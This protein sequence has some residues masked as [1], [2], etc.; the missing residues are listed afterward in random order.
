METNAIQL[1]KIGTSAAANGGSKNGFNG[2]VVS[3]LGD[4]ISTFT[5]YTPVADGHNLTHRNRYPQSDLLT[6][7]EDT[8]WYKLIKSLG[9]K[10]GI[11]DSWAGSRV[12]NSSSTNTGDQGPDACMASNTR[13]TNLGANGTPDL[14]LFYGG[15]NDCAA[16]VTIG[17]FDS[18][19]NHNTVDLDSTT[20]STFADAYA[21]A[22]M[23]LQHYYPDAKIVV[24]LPTYTATY[25][26]LAS[27]DA[28]NEVIKE[29]CDYF[30]VMVLDLRQSGI[31]FQNKGYTLG[32]GIHPTALG[33]DLIYRYIKEK[34][35]STYSLPSGN[36][37]V[38]MITS[39]LYSVTSTNGWWK[40]VDDGEEYTTVLAPLEDYVME[41][42][43][44]K[45]G[46]VDIT[47][48]V[49]DSTTKTISI[50]SV[51]GDVVITAT[52]RYAESVV[53]KGQKV[54]SNPELFTGNINTGA[55][56]WSY[57]DNPIGVPINTI[58]F[59]TS[60]GITDGVVT[61][62]V[63]ETGSDTYIKS[64]V[65]TYT[66]TGS[67]KEL[68]KIVFPE[69]YTL[70]EGQSLVLFGQESDYFHVH[71]TMSVSDDG[72]FYKVCPLQYGGTAQQQ[73]WELYNLGIHVGYAI[74]YTEV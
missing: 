29:I 70:E 53:Y 23:R 56:G 32:D 2:K 74:G 45:M 33:M 15:T 18:T 26:T 42:V 19:V 4:S 13:I 14:I 57:K 41:S 16:G 8:Y 72:Q 48:D 22:I 6:D 27:L 39:N 25:Y 9:A 71:H 66:K 3:I 17:S 65:V 30:G 60:V 11:N 55:R 34:L 52:A 31:N 69:T 62:G 38:R 43:V 61:M 24:L 10:L 44:V 37:V 51:N 64:Q 35:L 73:P 40:G 50:D 7:V 63:C 54:I 59:N 58:W 47:A 36:K 67:E 21:C 68:I 20:W 5:G 1:F 12:H 28:Y 49:Y 46:G